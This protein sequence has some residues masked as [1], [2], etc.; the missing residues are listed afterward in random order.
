MLRGRLAVQGHAG[1]GASIVLLRNE[2]PNGAFPI[3]SSPMVGNVGDMNLV[4]MTMRP[5]VTAPCDSATG[6][7]PSRKKL[8]G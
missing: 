1:V 7:T 4:K 8:F 2:V 3:P 5:A 6:A